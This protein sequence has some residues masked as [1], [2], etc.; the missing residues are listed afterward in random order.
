MADEQSGFWKRLREGMAHALAGDV[1]KAS[2]RTPVDPGIIAAAVQGNV[3]FSVEG[4]SPD[5]WM[6]PGQ[7]IAPQHQ[8]ARGR[9]WDY[10]VGSN[11][12]YTPRS[13]ETT[14]FS[15]MRA[16]ADGYDLLRLA[17]ETRKDQLAKMEW[18]VRPKDHAKKADSRCTEVEDFL[19]F[20]DREHNWD[21]WLRAIVEEMLVTDAATIYPQLTRG[22]KPYKFELFDGT[23]IKRVIDETGRTPEPPDVAYQQI[24]K[25]LPAVDYHRDELIY[26]PRNLR[27]SKLYGYSPVEQIIMTVNIAIRRQLFQLQFYTEGSVPDLILEVPDTWQPDQV[28]A[29]TDW[30]E[31]KLSGNTAARRAPMFVPKGVKPIN[32]KDGALKDE[33]DEWLARI[34]CYA[35]SLPATPFVKQ[36]NRSTSETVQEAALLEGLA[37]L[38]TW[39]AN[40][41]NR[42]IWKYWGYADITFAWV[43][44]DSISTEAQTNINNIK[45]RNATMTINE[46]RAEDGVDPIEG[47]DEPMIY[48]ASGAVL[49]RNILNPPEPPASA[50]DGAPA[51]GGKK[52]AGDQGAAK[53]EKKK[54]IK[55]INRD[56]K[57]VRTK[58]R[59]IAKVVKAFLAD[60]MPEA[61]QQIYKA[62][63]VLAKADQ[64]EIDAVLA[65]LEFEGWAVLAGD[66]E[67]L[68]E[69]VTRDGGAQALMQVGMDDT[70]I[71]E[72]VNERALAYA[73]DRAAE[74]V[75][76]KWVDGEL[77]D[78]P[79]ADYAITESTRDLLR[80][81]VAQA[82]DEQWGIDELASEIEQGNAFSPERADLIARTEVARADMEG[83]MAGYRESGVVEKKEWLISNDENVCDI[84][85]GNAAQGEIGLDD[86]FESGDDA[87]PAH[88]ACQC[89]LAPVVYETAPEDTEQ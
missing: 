66:I 27:V 59:A 9:A 10:G 83:S 19:R 33:Y 39:I 23:T 50:I 26:A 58:R 76:K 42:V 63:D 20:P 81:T 47:G 38:M 28:K 17:I 7:P 37:P 14:S 88:P 35:F 89:S 49:L 2:G 57:S 24:L 71:T 41:V 60:R 62:I 3:N 36:M 65:A 4:A 67:G 1:I 56:R 87:P 68:I 80:S 5:T 29:F 51:A 85:E 40:L 15:Q 11:L 6:G 77:V 72:Q 43:E 82:I 34:I 22:G 32:T 31:T 12:Q 45:I 73:Q 54:R 44:E 79:N 69:A 8:S 86:E 75:G 46:S 25:G 64:K 21:E 55:P 84:C 30:W 78:N 53:L 61:V 70:G 74:M 18:N 48:T 16:L 13:T 52:P